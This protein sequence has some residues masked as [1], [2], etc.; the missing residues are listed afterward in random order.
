MHLSTTR[1]FRLLFLSPSS[2]LG[3]LASVSF[4]YRPNNNVTGYS[5]VL[6]RI[7]FISARIGARAVVATINYSN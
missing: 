2:K 5:G 1:V 3:Y 4:L 7:Y 6:S